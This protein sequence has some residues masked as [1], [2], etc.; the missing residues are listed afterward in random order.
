MYTVYICTYIYTV[1]MPVLKSVF[2][3]QSP[4]LSTGPFGKELSVSNSCRCAEIKKK[5]RRA[6]ETSEYQLVFNMV[7]T[8]KEY[9]SSCKG[10]HFFLWLFGQHGFYLKSCWK[11]GNWKNGFWV[12]K[13]LGGSIAENPVVRR[14]G[15]HAF[16]RG[17]LKISSGFQLL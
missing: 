8:W 17:F 3:A 4:I 7:A 10:V 2:K 16:V 5:L 14:K 6:G 9:F 11:Y 15:W 13:V 1:Y 12:D